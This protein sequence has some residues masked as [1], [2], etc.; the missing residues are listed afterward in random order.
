MTAAER[1]RNARDRRRHAK[2][3]ERLVK[4]SQAAAIVAESVGMA[5][6]AAQ[7]ADATADDLVDAGF[8]AGM[9]TRIA[10]ECANGFDG[11]VDYLEEWY[12]G[13]MGYPKALFLRHCAAAGVADWLNTWVAELERAMA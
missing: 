13:A 1:Q 3:A 4:Q 9:A 11:G 2:E 7:G 10:I 8:E 6:G 12:S 5:I